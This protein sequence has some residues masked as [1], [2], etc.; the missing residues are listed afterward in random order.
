MAE[1]EKV[2]IAEMEEWLVVTVAT[3]AFFFVE[4][5]AG[6]RELFAFSS[7]STWMA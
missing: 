3:H 7:D 1:I 6:R 4:S 5:F 2:G